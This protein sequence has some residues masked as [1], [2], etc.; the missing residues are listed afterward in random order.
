[1]SNTFNLNRFL[2][3]FRR[4]IT[5]KG[6][7]MFGSIFLIIVAII[8]FMNIQVDPA[9]YGSVRQIFLVLGT[10]FGPIIYM[11]IVS[12]EFSNQSKG[13]SYL[14]IPN[15]RF[16][17]WLLNN[18]I[19]I[20]LYYV[21]FGFLF[22][23]VDLWMVGRIT[24][25]FG[26]PPAGMDMISFTS[27]I[28]IVSSMVGV[29][30]AVGV[31]LGALYFKKNSL[32]LSLLIM[33]L[34]FLVVF[35]GNY[36]IANLILDGHINMSDQSPFGSV[37]LTDPDTAAGRYFLELPYKGRNVA[38]SVFIPIVVILSLTYFVRIKEKQL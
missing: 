4:L 10:M 11:S 38:L 33:F 37:Y 5:E 1:M 9:S 20:A 2:L 17:K 21:V 30:I 18:I 35:F 36:F 13:I 32:I 8:L 15:S 34:V 7:K 26:L 31:L 6:I 19:V 28:F 29:S 27:D 22:R 12:N 14:L 3:A 23:L 16:E 25:K 24:E